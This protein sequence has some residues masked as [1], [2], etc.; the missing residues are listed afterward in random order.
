MP[1]VFSVEEIGLFSVLI[2]YSLLLSIFAS[3]GFSLVAVKMFSHF[4]SP[5][6]KHHGFFGMYLMVGLLGFVISILIYTSLKDFILEQNAEKSQLFAKYF[7]Y[8]IPI[9]FFILLF[10]KV[11]T[12]YC[13]LYNAVKGIVYKE[14]IQRVFILCAILLY[15]FELI[16]FHNSVIG[17]AVAY[18]LP[19]VLL[20]IAL[21]KS[22]SISFIPDFKFFK[23]PLLKKIS[24]VAFFGILISF[25]GMLVLNIDIIMISHF[26]GLGD[27][28]I[29]TTTFFFGTLILIP[30]R[31]LT[32]ISAVM[33]ADASKEK[34]YD[35]I[36]DIYKKSMG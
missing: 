33:I 35:V 29:Y 27:T 23:K 36:N 8:I 17:Y 32:K 24:S 18:S 4:R 10:T 11:D 14:V 9:T 20:F 25:S 31:S 5:E 7:Y 16:N 12:Y 2:S 15:Y 13:V 3:L 34:K 26:I 1:N 30:S 19:A 28:G 21:L 6:T 22:G